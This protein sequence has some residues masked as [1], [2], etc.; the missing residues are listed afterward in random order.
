MRIGTITLGLN[1]ARQPAPR[2]HDLARD[3]PW[4]RPRKIKL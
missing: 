3:V 2:N 4:C 1:Q